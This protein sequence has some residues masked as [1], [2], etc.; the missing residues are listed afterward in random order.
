MSHEGSKMSRRTFIKGVVGAGALAGAGGLVGWQHHLSGERQG[1]QANFEQ[2][3]ME[4]FNQRVK[5][6]MSKNW[7]QA[8]VWPGLAIIPSSVELYSSAALLKDSKI[9]WPEEDRGEHLVVQRPFLINQS[10]KLNQEPITN[11][12][13]NGDDEVLG[14]WL[15]G[16]QQLAFCDRTAHQDQILLPT[17]SGAAIY[18]SDHIG[19]V[20][21]PVVLEFP[22]KH[23]GLTYRYMEA[24]YDDGFNKVTKQTKVLGRSEWLTSGEVSQ[25][26]YAFQTGEG[27]DL[28]QLPETK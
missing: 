5:D 15:P 22:L 6:G 23:Q 26:Y 3:Q 19:I 18:T 24:N 27:N 4:L 7:F 11:N 25:S 20:G 14:F 9:I 21:E 8:T 17:H 16:S 28:I 1:K 13:A 2:Q 10:A 12:P